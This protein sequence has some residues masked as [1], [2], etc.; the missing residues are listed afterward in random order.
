MVKMRYLCISSVCIHGL[1]AFSI[2]QYIQSPQQQELPHFS[3]TLLTSP[4]GVE[5]KVHVASQKRVRDKVK[6]QSSAEDNQ[7]T[8]EVA[9]FVPSVMY[10]PAPAYPPNAK[11]NGQEGEFSVKLL[12][13][14]AGNVE[15][16]EV[17]AIK[18]SQE[19]FEEE[20]QATIKTWKFSP[21]SKEVSFEI[22]ISFRLD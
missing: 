1:L 14:I 22:P 7:S 4:K 18:G 21:S 15:H 5:E 13:N 12:V 16:I 17:I 2:G 19:L 6:K 3:V 11:A 9:P 20:L 10:N 8:T